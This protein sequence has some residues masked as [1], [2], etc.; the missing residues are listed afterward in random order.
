MNPE[1]VQSETNEDLLLPISNDPICQAMTL[2]L[3]ILI[4]ILGNFLIY[5]LM[6]FERFGGNVQRRNLINRM[7]FQVQGCIIFNNI[8]V[9][10]IDF[11]RFFLGWQYSENFCVIRNFSSKFIF[12]LGF[13]WSN[14]IV[15][16]R[17]VYH[18]VWK[19][20]KIVNDDF[21]LTFFMVGNIFLSGFFVLI[22]MYIWGKN[23]E[24][25]TICIGRQ[26]QE[27][28]LVGMSKNQS[29]LNFLPIIS[30]IWHIFVFIQ[31]YVGNLRLDQPL[32]P[33]RLKQHPCLGKFQPCS[34]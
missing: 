12:V 25:Y 15:G 19:S 7:V 22:D 3:Y 27:F 21:F 30:L 29:P 11:F 23:Q 16:V 20:V 17:Y 1:I 26:E 14:E 8:L 34:L 10:N 24:V 13:F 33:H 28:F 31:I 18:C 4:E 2:I 9:V 6:W 32:V 5:C